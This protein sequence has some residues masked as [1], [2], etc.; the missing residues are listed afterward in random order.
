MSGEVD[1]GDEICAVY[2]VS[3]LLEEQSAETHFAAPQ[4]LC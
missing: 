1:T 3:N 2:S 4:V